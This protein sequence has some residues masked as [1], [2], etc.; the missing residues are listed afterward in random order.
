MRGPKW[1]REEELYLEKYHGVINQKKI[2]AYLGKSEGAVR[3]KSRRMGLGNLQ[4]TTDRI[5]CSNVAEIIG[6]HRSVIKKTWIPKGL[7]TKKINRYVMI[8]ESDLLKFMQQH[9][10]LWDA[11]KCD[12]YFF[13]QYEWFLKKLEADKQESCKS[14][15]WTE[16][17]IAT[18]LSMRP[19]S[20][21]LISSKIRKSLCF[22]GLQYIFV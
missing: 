4:E 17:E 3:E 9:P 19:E 22:Q 7:K 15:F 18:L 14:K 20:V 1:S 10:E 6:I 11:K 12:Y 16:M 21:K 5:C 13:C 8:K 2:A